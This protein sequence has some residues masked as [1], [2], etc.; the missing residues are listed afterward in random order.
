MD[1]LH[2]QQLPHLA[3]TFFSKKHLKTVSRFSSMYVY[4]LLLV[5]V[6][7]VAGGDVVTVVLDGGEQ[8]WKADVIAVLE[9]EYETIGVY[10]T[11]ESGKIMFPRPSSAGLYHLHLSSHTKSFPMI[12]L[13][14]SDR[15]TLQV[16]SKSTS[17][18]LDPSS[19]VLYVKA[20]G[21]ARFFDVPEAF[22]L[23]G[24]LTSPMAL[25]AL[26]TVGMML[27]MQCLISGL[28][29]EEIR[30]ELRGGGEEDEEEEENATKKNSKKKNKNAVN[31]DKKHK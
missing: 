23:Y 24:L 22:S 7:A 4:V 11:Q 29:P 17:V 10:H 6:V 9:G 20:V 3:K 1:D 2:R 14:V 19:N 5:V 18:K 30:K 31:E 8:S 12:Q 15:S 13:E 16:H 26:T 21:D 25:M 28:D 27:V